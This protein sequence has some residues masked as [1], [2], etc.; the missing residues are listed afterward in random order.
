MAKFKV[1]GVKRTPIAKKDGTGTWMKMQ[2]KTVETAETVLELGFSF[3]KATKDNL[4]PG[5][6][7]TGYIE[8]RPWESNGKNGVN[9]I[10]N[11]ITAEYVYE[12]LLKINPNADK[13]PNTPSVATPVAPANTGWVG[14]ETTQT[15]PDGEGIDSDIPF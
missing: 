3:P 9:M 12:L 8:S 11:G 7:L 13:L 5:D 14:D 6:V 10:L 15:S 4:K 1:T 2:V